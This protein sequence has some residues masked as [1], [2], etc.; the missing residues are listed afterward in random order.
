MTREG[1]RSIWPL[2]HH[3]VSPTDRARERETRWLPQ[4]GPPTQI[5]PPVAENTRYGVFESIVGLGVIWAE[6]TTCKR[7]RCSF[8]L[9][10]KC[11]QLF[12]PADVIA[13]LLIIPGHREGVSGGSAA[14]R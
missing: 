9:V 14:P 1:V 5:P 11:L 8:G 12:S 4:S 7:Y 13:Y 6:K 3:C 2:R 10:Q